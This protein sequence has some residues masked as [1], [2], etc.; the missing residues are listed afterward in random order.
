MSARLK[1]YFDTSVIS[2]YFD[3]EK[4]QRQLITQKWFENEFYNFECYISELVVA[5]LTNTVNFEK[6]MNMMGLIKEYKFQE[7]N[8]NDEIEE[9]AER[10]RE[11]SKILS[12]EKSDSIHIACASY[13]NIETIVSWNFK[14]FVNYEVIKN[15]HK[16]NSE[17]NYNIIEIFSLENLGGNIWIRN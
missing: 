2:A 17:L 11:H 5:E 12:K 15:I 6:R 8:I 3:S 1:L 10:Y 7:L 9:L 13:F 14:H 16:V 4:P